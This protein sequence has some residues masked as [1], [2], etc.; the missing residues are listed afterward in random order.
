MGALKTVLRLAARLGAALLALALLGGPARALEVA[1]F[2]PDGDPVAGRPTEVV[3]VLARDGRPQAEEVPDVRVD[4]GL[5][6]TAPRAVGPGRW[7]VGW[8]P[9][10]EAGEGR[11]TV[12]AGGES[13]EARLAVAADPGPELAVE[14]P[15]VAFAGR[16]RPLAIRVRRARPGPPVDPDLLDV[17]VGEGKV[18][19]TRADGDAAVITWQP[20]PEPFPRA[21][22]VGVRERSHPGARPTWAVV[23]LRARPRIPVTTEPGTR[24]T[25]QVG[26]RRT[27]PVVAGPD[28]VA[29]L[30]PE[31]R[32]GE[33][34]ARVTLLDEAGNEQH[35]TL[36]IG[37]DPRPGIGL[38]LGEG[39]SLGRV[40][41]RVRVF[42]IAADGRPWTGP[43]P[44]C[45]TALGTRLPLSADGP[46]A[47]VGAPRIPADAFF[48]LR[49]DCDLHDQARATIRVPV[50]SS[51]PARLVLRA[52]PDE[53][54]ADQP[55][56]QVEAYVEDGRGDRLPAAGIR[57][58]AELGRLEVDPVAPGDA[59]VRAAYDGSAAAAAGADTLHARWDR[60]PG[61]G[62]PWT[63]R[64]DGARADGALRVVARVAD[65]T[66]APLPDVAVRF[67]VADPAGGPAGEP[68]ETRTDARGWARAA[69]PAPAAA[70]AVVEA[71][72]GAGDGPRGPGVVRRIAV[73]AG[74]DA[75]LSPEAADLEA[76]LVLPIRS[77]RVRGVFLSTEPRTLVVGR[78]PTA[79]VRLRLEGKDGVP[80]TDVPVRLEAS[81]GEI[82][83]LR[84]RDDGEWEARYRPPAR[85]AGLE[86]VRITARSD[87][88]S[89]VETATEIA[90]LPREVRR[91]PGV[92]VGYLLGAR[93]LGSPTV[94]LVGDAR[95]RDDRSVYL[96][97]SVSGY[98]L[99][100]HAAD[101]TTGEAVDVDL[102][103]LPV[104]LGGLLRQERDRLA[105]W[106]GTSLVVAPFLVDVR[107][108][109]ATPTSGLG[110][111]PPGV[112]LYSGAAWRFPNSEVAA[113]L[114]YLFLNASANGAGWDGSV[115]G[116]VGTLAWRLLY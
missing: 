98:A 69:L 43:A 20:G 16:D 94:G 46:G 48:D 23:S 39:V 112:H 42:A 74:Q 53:L 99:A 47:W 35:S 56:A 104:G 24:V 32:P 106:G 83:P 60:P 10:P 65:E 101:P 22:P 1:V 7:I 15:P 114:G 58:S 29:V 52:W 87:D 28:G 21:V 13:A 116:V 78:D 26:R 33:R 80:V 81:A 44:R 3:L 71:R 25:V 107:Y 77:G 34:L 54:V 17:V 100:A 62:P 73:L 50:R 89:F 40:E 82:G 49:V 115:G 8:T 102:R 96:R 37:G 84:L 51:R 88:G 4:A 9:P 19:S 59:A 64:L 31:V 66:G 68:V 27:G 61:E 91:A 92:T 12:T 75:R 111:A 41:P 72:A 2:A 86:T 67:A 76:D 95:L 36:V 93:G 79:R 45:V 63:L 85:V 70:I 113:E 103:L 57:L 6:D 110:L 5:L 109:G 30:R 105:L 55:R 38:M 97:A 18:L 11:F 90:L 14:V 108:G